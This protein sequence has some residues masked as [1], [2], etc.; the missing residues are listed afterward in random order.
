MFLAAYTMFLNVLTNRAAS[1]YYVM[2]RQTLIRC[3]SRNHLIETGAKNVLSPASSPSSNLVRDS[4]DARAQ[5]RTL[6]DLELP[7]ISYPR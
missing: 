2:S 5:P 1:D 4:V 3:D 6:M 7:V